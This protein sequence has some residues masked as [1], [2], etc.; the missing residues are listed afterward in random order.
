MKK[1]K[2]RE[3]E[4]WAKIRQERE[5]LQIK[6]NKVIDSDNK[7]NSVIGKAKSSSIYSESI[8]SKEA[9][10]I[11]KGHG[12]HSKTTMFDFSEINGTYFLPYEFRAIEIDTSQGQEQVAEQ[13]SVEKDLNI[14]DARNQEE[15]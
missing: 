1:F 6:K 5:A 4:M 3:A 11:E 2:A 9:S 14:Y 8:K 12:K 15:N 13:S 7:E 10:I